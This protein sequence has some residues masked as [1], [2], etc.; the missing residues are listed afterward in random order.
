MRC[1]YS[2]SAQRIDP[3]YWMMWGDVRNA[4]ADSALD[5]FLAYAQQLKDQPVSAADLDIAKSRLTGKFPLDIETPQQVA[6]QIATSLLL[7]QGKDYVQTWRQRVA[8]VSATDVQNA[9]K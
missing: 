8:A 7:G 4:V 2:Q 3:G 5:M 9:A 1:A 6:G